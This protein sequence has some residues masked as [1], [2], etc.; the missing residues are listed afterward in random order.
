[1]N[2]LIQN[3]SSHL[4]IVNNLWAFFV[5]QVERIYFLFFK[6]NY[7]LAHCDYNLGAL[8]NDLDLDDLDLVA[9]TATATTPHHSEVIQFTYNIFLK[10]PVLRGPI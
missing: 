2:L 3:I 4:F 6:F 9:D 8:V 7:N 10:H 5:A 1:M